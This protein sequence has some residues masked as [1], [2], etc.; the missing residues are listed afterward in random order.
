MEREIV[1]E[2]GGKMFEVGKN[3][4]YAKGDEKSTEIHFSAGGG[5]NVTSSETIRVPFKAFDFYVDDCMKNNTRADFRH[6]NIKN[7]NMVLSEHGFDT[8]REDGSGP[9]RYPPGYKL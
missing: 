8:L 7:I 3:N 1:F 4:W 2:T 6:E 9:T 5:G